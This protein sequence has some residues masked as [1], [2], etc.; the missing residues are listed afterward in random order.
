MPGDPHEPH[1]SPPPDPIPNPVRPPTPQEAPKSDP[2]PD[3]PTPAPDVIREPRP[4]D[5][6]ESFPPEAPPPVTFAGRF[7]S[8]SQAYC[9]IPLPNDQF[10]FL[11]STRLMKTSSRRRPSLEASP[12][13]IAL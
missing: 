1:P 8:R 13:A 10:S 7:A 5:I 12:S 4:D 6:P 3:L 11:T 9:A 2:P